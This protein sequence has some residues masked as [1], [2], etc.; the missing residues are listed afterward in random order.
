MT[1]IP[2]QIRDYFAQIGAKGGAKSRRT[3]TTEQAQAMCKA[4]KAKAILTGKTATKKGK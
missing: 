2:Q 4:R 3:L 1:A